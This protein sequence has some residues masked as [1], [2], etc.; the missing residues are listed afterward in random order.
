MSDFLGTRR[1]VVSVLAAIALCFVMVV[2]SS[3]LVSSEAQGVAEEPEADAGSIEYE[4][5]IEVAEEDNLSNIEYGPATPYTFT[6]EFNLR[7]GTGGPETLTYESESATEHT[8]TIPFDRPTREGPYAFMG[9][10]NS[11]IAIYTNY[12]PG[13]TITVESGDTVTLY[14]VWQKSMV[15]TLDANGG[16]GGSTKTFTTNAEGLSISTS[17]FNT[18]PTLSGWSIQGLAATSDSR[19]PQNG[20]SVTEDCTVYVIWGKEIGIYYRGGFFSGTSG[21]IME[22]T[23]TIFYGDEESVTIT[24]STTKPNSSQFPNDES[25]FLGWSTSSAATRVD[26]TGGEVLT[27]TNS[28]TLY[29]VWDI[30]YAISFNVNG[31]SGTIDDVTGFKTGG[32]NTDLRVLLPTDRPTRSGYTFIGWSES[33]SS[34]TVDAHP[35]TYYNLSLDEPEITLYALWG[36]RVTLTYDANGGSDAPS[37]QNAYRYAGTGSA[38]LTIS[39]SEPVRPGYDFLGWSLSSTASTATYQPG[40]TILLSGNDVLYAVWEANG[41]IITFDSMGGSAVSPI[42][43]NAGSVATAPSD[44][45]LEYFVFKG[46]YTSIEFSTEYTFSEPVNSSFTLYA[47]WD[48]TLAF[49]SSPVADAQIFTIDGQ[50]Y[51]FSAAKSVGNVSVLWDFGDG[52]TSNDTYESHTYGVPGEYT[53]TLTVYNSYGSDTITQDIVVTDDGGGG[54][55]TSYSMPSVSL[56]SSSSE[57]WSSEDCCFDVDVNVVEAV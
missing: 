16:T 8:F 43:V 6:V 27:L 13:R 37:A 9:W 20:I 18:R 45:T 30:Y 17:D 15:V 42:T 5:E 32:P 36:T 41:F 11:S 51:A 14:A 23:E 3:T 19:D 31:G 53:V 34:Y 44:P 55:M 54:A 35:G 4:A 50:T 12:Y 57:V 48:G 25:E 46:W 56:Q 28:L 24:V 52:T 1:N 33:R 40:D 47:K 22:K 38:T 26:Y 2:V 29:A 7:G 39:S 49:T 21:R 10:S